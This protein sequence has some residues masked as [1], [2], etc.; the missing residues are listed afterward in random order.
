MDIFTSSLKFSKHESQ[1][2]GNSLMDALG[3][4]IVRDPKDLVS[5]FEENLIYGINVSILDRRGRRSHR[6]CYL[7]E[8]SNSLLCFLDTETG[9][10]S[11]LDIKNL[12]F[13]EENQMLET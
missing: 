3:N 8:D 12:Q 6:I 2:Q 11:I 4:L 1:S 7:H 13:V 5:T 9:Y 10:P